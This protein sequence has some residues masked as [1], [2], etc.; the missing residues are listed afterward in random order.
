MRPALPVA[1]LLGAAAV[2]CGGQ[3]PARPAPSATEWRAN[4]R[5]V[6]EQLR[7]DVESAAIGGTS[8][9]A[10]AR[11]LADTSSLYALLV[12]YADLGG[13]RAMVRA[14]APPARVASVVE[15][16][17]DRLQRASALFARAVQRSDP[18]ALVRATAATAG[19]EPQLVRAMLAIRR[20]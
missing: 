8:R 15:P 18:A 11:A 20:G 5:Q 3:P 17:C 14:A 12:A 19:A 4:T 2:G 9:A 13:C 10:A 16:A 7:V 1:A 6:V